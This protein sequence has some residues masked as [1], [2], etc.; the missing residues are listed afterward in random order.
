MAFP[1]HVA[2]ACCVCDICKCTVSSSDCMTS[3]YEMWMNNGGL[4]QAVAAHL[5]HTPRDSFWPVTFFQ[6]KWVSVTPDGES[7]VG[8]SKHSTTCHC[9]CPKPHESSIRPQIP[10]KIHFNIIP[11]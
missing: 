3:N 4:C 9:S 11:I 6:L 1:R 5:K 2:L 8:C 7:L 10:F